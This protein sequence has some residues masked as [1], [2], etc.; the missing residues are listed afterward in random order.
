MMRLGNNLKAIE[1]AA[2][3]VK[4]RKNEVQPLAVLTECL[5][6][7]GKKDEAIL[8]LKEL[9]L[10]SGDVDLDIPI[11]RRITEIA[12]EL[13]SSGAWKTVAAK[14]TDTGKRPPID[15]LGPFLWSPST[16]AGF[17]L[18]TKDGKRVS[19]DDFRKKG[20]PVLIVFYLGK[21]CKLCMEQ[22]N[23]IAP[24]ADGFKSAG[25]DIVA[26]SADSPEGL[27]K[28]FSGAGE[29]EF[30]FPL[31]SDRHFGAF[32]SYRAYDDFEKLPLHGLFL[33]DGKGLIRWQDINFEPF[34]DTKFLL[35][36]SKRLLRIGANDQTRIVA[37]D[38]KSR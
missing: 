14:P 6:R 28:T 35:E 34:K 4:S 10:I 32:K 16:A 17:S 38:V 37:R 33:V 7:G 19:L 26:I 29:K 9:Q 2:E 30:P 11:F 15:A 13:G 24:V 31:L 36:E 3:A 1:F 21:Y 5:Y 8:R 27:K 22:L 25:I 23:L 18:P 20:K 12:P